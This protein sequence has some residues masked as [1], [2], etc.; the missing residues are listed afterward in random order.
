MD[1]KV[2]V[3]LRSASIVTLHCAPEP[4]H[5]PVQPVNVKPS[6]G[7]AVKVTVAPGGCSAVQIAGPLQTRPPPVT[8]PVPVTVTES[9]FVVGVVVGSAHFAPTVLLELKRTVQ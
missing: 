5:C 3:T 4:E 6:D 7:S 9:V 2:A 1:V 8:L